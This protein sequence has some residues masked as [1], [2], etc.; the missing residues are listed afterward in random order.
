MK[1]SLVIFAAMLTGC[2]VQPQQSQ[3]RWTKP[4]ATDQ[5]FQAQRSKCIYEVTMATQATDTSYRTIVI[6]EMERA[7]RQRTLAKLC[8]ESAGFYLQ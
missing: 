3:Q 1:L 7:Q 4:G 8:M 2:A 6:Q 5:E